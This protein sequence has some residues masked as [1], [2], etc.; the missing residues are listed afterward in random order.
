MLADKAFLETLL[1]Y[2]GKRLKHEVDCLIIGGNAM[3]YYG[4]R[5]QT[6]DLDMIFFRK[7]DIASVINII[8]GHPIY[9][10]VKQTKK[11]PYHIRPE[12]RK[13]GGPVFIG[14]KDVPRFDLFYKN[15]FSIDAEPIF[16]DADKSVIFGLLKIRLPRPEHLIFLKGAADRPQ[17]KEDIVRL[18][19]S[20]EVEWEKFVNIAKEYYKENHRA[21]YFCL[22]SLYDINEKE[23][24]IPEG[25]LEKLAKLSGMEV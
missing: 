13:N 22:G 8:K 21:V 3:L 9:R 7:Q 18:I 19:R 17:D 4:L 20:A 25:V 23:K 6:K 11:I 15:V 2:I 24:I 1:D 12:L 10:G 5:G 16:R 14:S